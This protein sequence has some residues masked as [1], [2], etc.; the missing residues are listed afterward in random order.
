[1]YPTLLWLQ[2]YLMSLTHNARSKNSTARRLLILCGLLI[3]FALRLFR[4]GSES[5]WYDET[6]SVV[7]ATK[8]IPGL[9]AHTAGDI[10]PPG[11][12]LLLHGWQWLTHP[13]LAHGLEFLYTWPSLLA[14]MVILVLL[15]ALGRRLADHSVALLALWLA[16]CNPFHVWYSQEVRMYTLG[17]ALGLLCL[18]SLIQFL[19]GDADVTRWPTTRSTLPQARGGRWLLLYV[20]TGVAGLYTLY[21]FLFWLVGLNLIVLLALWQ[22]RRTR[23]DQPLLTPTLSKE[24]T[25][26]AEPARWAPWLVWIAAQGAL[27][28][29]WLPWLPIFWRQATEP[30]VPPWRTT[31]PNVAAFAQD[32]SASLSALLLGQSPPGEITWPWALLTVALL[33]LYVKQRLGSVTEIGGKEAELTWITLLAT[34]TPIVLLYLVTLC[35]TP[36]YHVRYLFLYAPPFLLV[37]ASTVLRLERKRPKAGLAAVVALLLLNGLGLQQF[38]GNPL[39]RSDEHR[40][41]VAHLAQAWRPGD[42]ILVNA[43]WAYTIL[44]T[45]WPGEWSGPFAAKLPALI[46]RARLSQTL[47]Q[48]DP[49]LA[50]APILVTTG[51]LDG[52]TTL[53]WGDPNSDFFAMSADETMAALTRWSN[54]YRRIWHYRL[55]DTVNDPTGLIRTWLTSHATLRTEQAIP[56]RDL[57]LLQLYE[58]NQPTQ[59]LPMMGDIYSLG[60]PF[61]EAVRLER[62]AFA[63]SQGAGSMLYVYSEWQALSGISQLNSDLSISLR[64]Y[65][66]AGALLAQ[67][68][69]SAALPKSKWQPGQRANL[70]LAV[71]IPVAARPGDYA[72]VLVL[73]DVQSGQTLQ[74]QAARPSADLVSL[75]TISLTPPPPMP[76]HDT[77]IARFDY[78]ELVAV[79]PSVAVLKAGALWQLNL[80]WRPRPSAY[81]DTYLAQLELR[82]SSSQQLIQQWEQPLGGWG[83]PSAGWPASLPVLD[84]HRLDL[85]PGTPPGKYE[86]RLRL[87]R[88]HDR[89]TISARRGWGRTQDALLISRVTLQ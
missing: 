43:G 74:T 8:S 66:E 31:W 14:G 37:V 63:H 46:G 85:A 78:L 75:G 83:D 84:V 36:L 38:W 80:V 26:G 42:L 87:L 57:G 58:L 39:Y 12:Y 33:A 4:L 68:D 61:A 34:L 25:V 2:T 72:V 88:H 16:A 60:Y 11:Y 40:G 7:L 53:G 24:G 69:A 5:L 79:H 28:V 22:S 89:Q 55:Y 3:G 30:P 29:L 15:Y 9:I 77:A 52:E 82:D 23:K 10:H 73:Y 65:T 47:G 6:V 45:Y 27:L 56:G 54:S 51:S 41:A 32:L 21:Y 62:V 64:L 86:V 44:Q 35:W 18:W 76:I 67:Q 1:L 70:I 81:T 50:Q 49:G 19:H 71:P 20:L 59:A 13:T 17:A 48:G